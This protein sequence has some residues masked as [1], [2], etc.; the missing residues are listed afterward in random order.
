M[1]EEEEAVGGGSEARED[2]S[3]SRGKDNSW[4][5]GNHHQIAE[6]GDDEAEQAIV[7]GGREVLEWLGYHGDEGSDDVLAEEGLLEGLQHA[8]LL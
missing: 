8:L 7:V 6:C 2:N 1:S 3:Q 4:R 5:T